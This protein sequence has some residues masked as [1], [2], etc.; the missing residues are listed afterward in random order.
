MQNP[1]AGQAKALWLEP[2][3]VSGERRT[4][5]VLSGA[6]GLLPVV[7][8]PTCTAPAGR[9]WVFAVHGAWPA[10]R[11]RPAFGFPE[12]SSACRGRIKPTLFSLGRLPLGNCKDE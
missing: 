5:E 4:I 2:Q 9:K 7:A 11:R 8:A 12:A 6:L 3:A 10:Q 1:S